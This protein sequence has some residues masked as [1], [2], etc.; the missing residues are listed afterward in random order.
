MRTQTPLLPSAEVCHRMKARF[1]EFMER[2]ER[3]GVQYV[4]VMPREDDPTSAIGR[5]WQST[6]LTQSKGTN[7]LM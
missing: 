3:F 6:F 5:G 4:R 1:P 7:G 2:L